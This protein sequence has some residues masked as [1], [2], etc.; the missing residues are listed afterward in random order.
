[1]CFPTGVLVM[2]LEKMSYWKSI[3]GSCS[4][5]TSLLT[6]VNK[7]LYRLLF[8]KYHF[9]IGKHIWLLHRLCVLF[10][11][12][13]CAVYFQTCWWSQLCFPCWL[14][15]CMWSSWNEE[16]VGNPWPHCVMPP[17]FPPSKG[18]IHMNYC[19]SSLFRQRQMI[20]RNGKTSSNYSKIMALHLFPIWK[21]P[22]NCCRGS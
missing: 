12:R 6:H 17:H 8:V 20:P 1:M 3:S 18:V 7:G 5:L 13:R 22:I 11:G 14:R 2:C 19:S 15:V 21:T 4:L 16:A 10:C 9:K